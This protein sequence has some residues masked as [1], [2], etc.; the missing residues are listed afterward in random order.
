MPDI[1]ELP[2]QVKEWLARVQA[3][4]TQSSGQMDLY[5]NQAAWLSGTWPLLQVEGFRF[6][7]ASVDW[8]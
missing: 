5:D 6:H 7:A 4:G 8:E 2:R 1:F 3:L